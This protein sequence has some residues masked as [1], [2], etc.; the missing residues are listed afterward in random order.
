MRSSSAKSR[1]VAVGDLPVL[2]LLQRL[3]LGELSGLVVVKGGL[4]L[5][6]IDDCLVMLER[7]VGSAQLLRRSSGLEVV[8]VGAG[9]AGPTDGLDRL[10][11]DTRDGG[12]LPA[13]RGTLLL[14]PTRAALGL[15][16]LGALP[17]TRHGSAR[18]LVRRVLSAPAAVFAKL[19]PIRVVALRLL[20]LVVPPLA[21]LACEGHGDSNVSACHG[22]FGR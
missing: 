11:R 4:V 13:L 21:L 6:T 12:A 19:N 17:V 14:E 3:L 7:E 5:L 10:G 20:G 8:G 16:L 22:S 9:R 18:L 15:A 1:S 2:D